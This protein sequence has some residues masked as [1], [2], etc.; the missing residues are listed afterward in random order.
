MLPRWNRPG[1]RWAMWCWTRI[2]SRVW[3]GSEEISLSPTEFRLLRYLM[4]NRERVV[5]DADHRSCVGL[6]FCGR[7][8]FGRNLCFVST[9]Q[10]ARSRC[11][12]HPHRARL[13]LLDSRA[14]QCPGFGALTPSSL[15]GR[16]SHSRARHPRHPGEV[17]RIRTRLTLAIVAILLL[18][19]GSLGYVLVRDTRAALVRDVDEDIINNVQRKGFK[20]DFHGMEPNSQGVPWSRSEWWRSPTLGSRRLDPCHPGAGRCHHHR[21]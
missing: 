19:I 21:R 15:A 16:W 7:S 17:G 11:T 13:R 20:P 10:T 12:A 8:G 18:T 5:Y 1:C 3:R 2:H 6:R 4:L 9:T 14:G